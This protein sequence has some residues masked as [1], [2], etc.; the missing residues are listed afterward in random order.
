M[1]WKLKAAIQRAVALLPESLSYAAYYAIQ[2]RFGGLRR[3]NPVSRLKAGLQVCE[4]LEQ[5]GRS[6]VGGS[7]LEIGTGRRINMPLAF[8]L[9]GAERIVTVDL[10]PYLKRELVREDLDY[11]QSHRTEIEALFQ[12]RL[13]RDRLTSLLA[14][15]SSAWTMDELLR[16]CGIEY[17]AP[18][19]AAKLPL[20]SH[21]I[22]FHTSF[23]V[24][25]SLAR[26]SRRS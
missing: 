20:P 10:N 24:F 25:E 18:G 4:R 3:M 7:F 17:L 1:N 5:A 23:T 11:M 22:D 14:F 19:D 15:A 6:P 13:D 16:Y 26:R 21:S 2:R 8:W 12:E 9:L